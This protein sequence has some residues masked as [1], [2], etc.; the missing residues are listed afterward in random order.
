MV[1]R[2]TPGSPAHNKKGR[3]MKNQVSCRGE[4]LNWQAIVSSSF[5]SVMLRLTTLADIS[6]QGF[7][8]LKSVRFA[9]IGSLG[10]LRAPSSPIRPSVETCSEADQKVVY[11]TKIDLANIFNCHK[12]KKTLDS[13]SASAAEIYDRYPPRRTRE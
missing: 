5:C 9:N 10:R 7:G 6:L 12:L 1:E 8:N 3:T 4:G 2:G 13:P 11:D